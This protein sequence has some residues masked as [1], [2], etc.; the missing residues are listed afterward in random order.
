MSPVALSLVLVVPSASLAAKVAPWLRKRMA[1]SVSANRSSL[2]SRASSLSASDAPSPS[3][4]AVEKLVVLCTPVAPAMSADMSPG[5]S[6]IM[7]SASGMVRRVRVRG[8]VVRVLVAASPLP[9]VLPLL[10]CSCSTNNESNTLGLVSSRS[11]VFSNGLSFRNLSK[12]S[13]ISSCSPAAPAWAI[14]WLRRNC[15]W[16]ASC[17]KAGAFSRRNPPWTALGSE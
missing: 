16:A 1:K 14:C 10:P 13:G 9:F 12:S 7:D 2:S 3:R 4:S 11:T 5:R 15:S 8:V 17:G 6:S